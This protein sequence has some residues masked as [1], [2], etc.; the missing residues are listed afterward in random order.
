MASLSLENH[1][2]Q[3]LLPLDH[4]WVAL[5]ME[6]TTLAP[7]LPLLLQTDQQGRSYLLLLHPPANLVNL[8]TVHQW[9]PLP[10]QLEW[11]KR[12]WQLWLSGT[13]IQSSQT[14]SNSHHRHP[15]PLPNQK[16]KLERIWPIVDLPYVLLRK[17]PRQQKTIIDSPEATYEGNGRTNYASSRLRRP[18]S[19]N[20]INFRQLGQDE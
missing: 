18:R 15:L 2:I 1:W 9:I 19:S 4:T 3:I 6:T 14:S 20:S 11:L 16:S 5:H 8:K 13:L 17:Q 12:Q 7:P 10:N